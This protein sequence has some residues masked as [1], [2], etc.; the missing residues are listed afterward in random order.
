MTLRFNLPCPS[1]VLTNRITPPDNIFTGDKPSLPPA[2]GC[3]GKAGG[4]E[5]DKRR[6]VNVKIFSIGVPTSPS[7]LL[8]KG[9]MSSSLKR[10]PKSQVLP[11]ASIFSV[12]TTT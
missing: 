5:G 7:I 8:V 12:S 3:S 1:R 10:L 11:I 2:S 9:Q 4:S 6:A